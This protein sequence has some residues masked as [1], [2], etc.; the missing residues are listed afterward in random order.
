MKSLAKRFGL[1]GLALGIAAGVRLIAQRNTNARRGLGTHLQLNRINQALDHALEKARQ[2]GPHPLPPGHRYVL[3]SDHHKGAGDGADDFRPCKA[4]YL[5]A[6]AEYD[7]RGYSLIILGDAEELWENRIAQ[8][9]AAHSDVFESERRFYPDRYFRVIGN[10]DDSWE[11]EAT[12]RHYLDP[13]FPG[14]KIYP[15]LLFHYQSGPH[16]SGE[17]YLAHGH[18]GTLDSDT[19][20]FLPPLLLPIYRV[21]QILTG[22][23]RTSPSQDECLRGAHDT[24]MYHW[25]STQGKLI[26]IAGHTHRPVWSSRTH[27]EKLLWQYTSLIQL[28]PEQRPTDYA[29]QLN[30]LKAEIEER[31]AK[32]PPCNDTIKTRPSYFN[33]GCCRFEDGD[34]TG[35]EL[36][37]GELRLVK[38]GKKEA[39][40]QRV[41]L[42]RAPLEEIFALL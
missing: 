37:D 36:E 24:Q 38:W 23:G 30:Y 35:I 21:I 19:F 9:F 10:H 16:T 28:K 26:L 13:Y 33:T 11:S 39:Q 42:E 6:L 27:L 12:V 29:E 8:V 5:H 15:S 7:Q 40:F 4:T 14:I 31:E 18:Q 1:I 3:F 17:L 32:F 2:A 41:E 25:A 22:I 20:R 34:I